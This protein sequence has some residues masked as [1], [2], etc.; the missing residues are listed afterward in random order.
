VAV[1]WFVPLFGL[2]PL[3]FAAVDAAIGLTRRRNAVGGSR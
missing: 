2:S 3:G 1:G